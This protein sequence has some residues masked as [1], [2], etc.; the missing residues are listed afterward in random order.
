MFKLFRWL[1][2]LFYLFSFSF[3]PIF[4]SWYCF[5]WVKVWWNCENTWNISKD[6]N[7]GLRLCCYT[8]KINSNMWSVEPLCI[9]KSSI[10]NQRFISH[11]AFNLNL[12]NFHPLNKFLLHMFQYFNIIL[13]THEKTHKNHLEN[14]TFWVFY[15]RRVQFYFLKLFVL[16]F[17]LYLF[18]LYLI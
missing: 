9:F 4:S 7:V 8:S 16:W 14:F 17:V 6:L 5:I 18:F 15:G 13:S 2:I 11:T 12:R 3:Y 10:K 1:L